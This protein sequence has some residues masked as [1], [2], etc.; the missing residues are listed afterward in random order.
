MNKITLDRFNDILLGS[1]VLGD[2]NLEFIGFKPILEAQSFHISFIKPG[3]K[4]NDE[5]VNIS[6]AGCIVCDNNTLSFYQGNLDKRCFIINDNPQLIFFNMINSLKSN[7]NRLIHP[8]ALISDNCKLGKN[9]SIGAYCIIGACII[10]DDTVIHEYVKIHDGVEIGTACNIRE[11]CSIGGEGF[12][13]F[14]DSNG[15]NKQ[16]PHI[17]KVIIGNYVSVFP[18]SNIDRATL[19]ETIVADYVCIDHYCHIGHNTITGKNTIITA[20]CVLAGGSEIGENSF[21]GVNTA[22]KEKIRVG[23]NVKTGMGSIVVK[24]IPDNEIW[25]GVP[26]K[27]HGQ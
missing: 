2:V 13:F 18:F 25:V 6:K 15:Y 1:E 7:Q 27:K 19:S 26:A 21:L 16:M 11:Y 3:A 24:D 12:G 23:S 5:I 8:T 9:V 4:K 14:K 22:V 10:G 17:G 20:G